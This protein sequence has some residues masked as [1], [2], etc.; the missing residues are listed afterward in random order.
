[1][2][3]SNLK[4]KDNIGIVLSY[5]TGI[6][7]IVFG[8]LGILKEY[9]YL[10][11]LNVSSDI[12][13]SCT[14][15][16]VV[17]AFIFIYIGYRIARKEIMS[18]KFM[19]L[20]EKLVGIFDSYFDREDWYKLFLNGGCYWYASVLCELVE[21]AYLVINRETEHCAVNIDGKIYDI[22]GEINK[23][24]FRKA[25]DR[26]ISFMKKNYKPNF[27]TVELSKF[28]IEKLNVG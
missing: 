9:G 25:S 15:F 26:D 17:V 12:L 20:H 13:F 23:Y 11:S 18:V 6:V 24:G 27:D 19:E 21:C 8:V 1:M 14:I 22:T 7:A 3:E 10:K 16:L 5:V 4:I 28:L 2:R